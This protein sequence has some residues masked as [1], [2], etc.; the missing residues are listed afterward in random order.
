MLRAV[1]VQSKEWFRY[2]VAFR[3][4]QTLEINGI[5]CGLSL[6]VV[7][8]RSDALLNCLRFGSCSAGFIGSSQTKMPN[9]SVGRRRKAPM[10]I[11]AEILDFED[12]PRW[13]LLQRS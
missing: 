5:H 12:P 9:G 3:S 8:R 7:I 13:R 2:W 6:V 11:D 10:G 1:V 4:E